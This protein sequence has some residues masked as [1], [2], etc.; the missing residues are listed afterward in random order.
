MEIDLTPVD[1]DCMRCGKTAPMRFYGICS[2]CR[3]QLREKFDREARIIEVPED[4]ERFEMRDARSRFLA[5]V[6][7][8][9]VQQG[10]QLAT[11]GGNG[12]SG[13]GPLKK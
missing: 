6:P 11:T 8:G 12:K 10:R 13:S 3:A 2:D 7:P 4:L 1:M 5:Y 9:S